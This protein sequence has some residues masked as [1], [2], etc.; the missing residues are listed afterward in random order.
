VPGTAL[1]TTELRHRIGEATRRITQNYQ[2]GLKEVEEAKTKINDPELTVA[3]NGSAKNSQLNSALDVL[4]QLTD[5]MIFESGRASEEYEKLEHDCKVEGSESS[6]LND[7][8]ELCKKTEEFAT[9]L[10][11]YS[12]AHF[13][14]KGAWN[15]DA[16]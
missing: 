4:L 8:R 10:L 12:L 14:R 3:D 2:K 6:E 7:L 11:C 9:D 15:S 13:K 16:A 5:Y 1:T